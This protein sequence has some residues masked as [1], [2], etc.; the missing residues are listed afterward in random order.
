MGDDIQAEQVFKYLNRIYSKQQKYIKMELQSRYNPGSGRSRMN[1]MNYF[2]KLNVSKEINVYTCTVGM[3]LT[4]AKYYFADQYHIFDMLDQLNELQMKINDGSLDKLQR[5]QQKRQYSLAN[6]GIGRFG[7][8][9][10][11]TPN[12]EI[13]SDRYEVVKTK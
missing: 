1:K 5:V 13:E 3:R 8:I 11:L 2:N 4:Q 7:A 9:T 12:R 10:K 6:F